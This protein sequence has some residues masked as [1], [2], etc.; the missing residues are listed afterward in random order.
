M[1]LQAGTPRADARTMKPIFPG[2]A[3]ATAAA[4][5]EPVYRDHAEVVRPAD[6]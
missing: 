5:L 4:L 6:R 3:E 1:S 2:Q